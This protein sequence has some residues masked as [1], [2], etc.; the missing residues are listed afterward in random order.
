MIC[1]EAVAFY[2]YWFKLHTHELWWALPLTGGDK[3]SLP[4]HNPKN[5]TVNHLQLPAYLSIIYCTA[6]KNLFMK[7]LLS[8]IY[9]QTKKKLQMTAKT[10]TAGVS[11]N[12]IQSGKY[13]KHCTSRIRYLS[14]DCICNCNFYALSFVT[15]RQSRWLI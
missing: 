14:L 4:C 1:T 12:L 7:G 8:M 6:R 5:G 9:M 15:Y 3:Y 11:R 2:L 10:N 13:F